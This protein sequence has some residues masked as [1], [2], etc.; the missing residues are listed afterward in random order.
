M[1]SGG[2]ASPQ[3]KLTSAVSLQQ[4]EFPDLK[5]MMTQQERPIAIFLQA[6]W[7]KFCRNMEQTTLKNKRVI[8]WLNDEYYFISF[9]GEHKEEVVFN[10]HVFGYQPTGRNT[11]IHDLAK[12]LGSIAGELT[13]PAFVILNPKYEIVFQYNAFLTA[14][15]LADVLEKGVGN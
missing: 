14:R 10:E 15:A 3:K 12:A 4:Y 2:C 7:C 11:G 6:A 1:V 8:N 13:F 5:K 9:D